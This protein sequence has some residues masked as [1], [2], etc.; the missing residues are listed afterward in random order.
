M[1][2]RRPGSGGLSTDIVIGCSCLCFVP[3]G[4]GDVWPGIT[5]LA[6]G[7]I[8]PAVVQDPSLERLYLYGIAFYQCGHY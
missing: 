2:G 4:K 1:A 5:G 3:G 6:G 8:L 7:V